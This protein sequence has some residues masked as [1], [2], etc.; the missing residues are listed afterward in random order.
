MENVM[1]MT[2]SP[3]MGEIFQKISSWINESPESVKRGFESAVPLSMAGL[4]ESASTQEGAQALL[5]TIKRGEYPHLDAAEL[6]RTMTNPAS[7]AEVARSGEGFLSK[8][9]GS[10]TSGAVDGVANS[11]GVSPSSAA[12]LL[13][14]AAPLVMGFIGKRA[15]SSNMDASGLR[16]FLAGQ[17][18]QIASALPGPLGSLFGRKPTRAVADPETVTGR[19]AIAETHEI[20]AP[21][22]KSG[23]GRWLL[24]GLMAAAALAFLVSRR[25]GR[26]EVPISREVQS[27]VAA[28]TERPQSLMAGGVAAL[29]TALDGSGALPKRF[30]LSELK[31]RT[32][33]AEVDPASA[34]VLDEVAQVLSAHPG[35]RIRVEGHTDNTGVRQANLTLSQQRAD[36]TRGYLM[37]K[38]VPGDRIE[39]T[40]FGPDRA[41]SPNDTEPGRAENRRTEIVAL[42]R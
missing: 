20:A 13:G 4:A 15:V 32:D 34:S 21:T 18:T 35:A 10:K 7:A 26:R 9:F 16:G 12:K 11:A 40:G 23:V 30:V 8:L 28:L 33:S 1:D 14:L 5:A 24:L 2:R 3:L 22:R 36:S 37:E 19:R 17:R 29:S 31:F 39:A 6:G 42:Q 41:L 27:Q 38:G 25:G